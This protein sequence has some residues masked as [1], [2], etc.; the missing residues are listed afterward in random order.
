MATLPGIRSW[1]PNSRRPSRAALG[2]YRALPFSVRRLNARVLTGARHASLWAH[3]SLH[4]TGHRRTLARVGRSRRNVQHCANFE[5]WDKGQL[6]P[7]PKTPDMLPREYTRA[8]SKDPAFN[9]KEHAFQ[10]VRVL[11][12]PTPRWTTFDAKFFKVALPKGRSGEHPGACLRRSPVIAVACTAD[13]V[14]HH[15]QTRNTRT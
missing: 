9:A 8:F 11:E 5:R 13:P 6:G 12:I 2:R 15:A 4:S 1:F 7:A 14:D 3:C 10:S